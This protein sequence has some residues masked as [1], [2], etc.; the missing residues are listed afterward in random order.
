MFKLVWRIGREAKRHKGLFSIAVISTILLT[1]VNLFAPRVL[2]N[3]IELIT[4]EM[5]QDTL[6]HILRLTMILLGLYLLR[7]LFRYLS[8]YISH[9]AAW[10]LVR[11]LRQ[12]VYDHIQAFSMS[13]FHNKQ[14]GDLMS[15]VINDTATF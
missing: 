6:E 1:M 14:T 11:D 9:K 7:V 8:S 15:R 13:F 4:N 10:H 2:T 3:M 5:N 12:R